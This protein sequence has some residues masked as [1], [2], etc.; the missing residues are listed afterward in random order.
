MAAWYPGMEGIQY[1]QIVK[2]I[3]SISIVNGNCFLIEWC[4][5][6]TIRFGRRQK[7]LR[8]QTRRNSKVRIIHRDYVL[9]LYM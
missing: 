3:V 8:T 2:I 1:V 6:D 5:M 7:K 4:K 9:D